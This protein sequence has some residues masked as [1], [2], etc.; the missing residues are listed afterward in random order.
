MT[1]VNLHGVHKGWLK[2]GHM[3]AHTNSNFLVTREDHHSPF[4]RGQTY[5]Q[6]YQV[7]LRVIVALF[8]LITTAH[9]FSFFTHV[10]NMYQFPQLTVCLHLTMRVPVCDERWRGENIEYDQRNHRKEK[11]KLWGVYGVLVLYFPFPSLFF[12]SS[13]IR[14][15][16]VSCMASRTMEEPW[17]GWKGLVRT[18]MMKP[19]TRTVHSH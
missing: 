19:N 9:I 8:L 11:R 6:K 16:Y 17:R 15:V 2:T 3:H 7:I 10:D 12:G 1:F 18:D 14:H 4:P 13:V 5:L